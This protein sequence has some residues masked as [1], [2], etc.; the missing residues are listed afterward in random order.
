M[1][2]NTRLTFALM[3]TNDSM[4]GTITAEL[5]SSEILLFDHK[6]WSY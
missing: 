2:I 5:N 6:S 3:T 1:T 4:H